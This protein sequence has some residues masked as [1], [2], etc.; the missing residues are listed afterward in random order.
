VISY[1][2]ALRLI[3]SLP[4]TS[5]RERSLV[6]KALHRVLAE[7]V[8]SSMPHPFWNN[9]AMDGYAYG[10]KDV[11]GDVMGVLGTQY[12]GKFHVIPMPTSKNVCVKVMTGSPLPEWVDTVVPIEH[13][14]V[15]GDGVAFV[16]RPK[17]GK[18]VRLK[19]SDIAEGETLMSRGTL[20]TPE[21][22]MVLSGLGIAEV[23]VVKQPR[24]AVLCTGDELLEPGEKMA[25]GMVYNSSLTFLEAV[26][27]C[28]EAGARQS[29]CFDR[30]D[31]ANDF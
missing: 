19:A 2:E 9:S 16:Q 27:L 6:S 1:E 17:A 31:R 7:D 14:E 12:A 15:R 21:R 8:R 24:V 28:D 20:L 18:N 5:R 23:E 3:K 26:K 30:R 22:L 29:R 10:D 13:V 11:D 25:P 4:Q